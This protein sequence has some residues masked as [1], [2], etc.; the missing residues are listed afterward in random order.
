MHVAR[1]Q[2]RRSDRQACALPCTE[3]LR[4]FRRPSKAPTVH[5]R[6][7]NLIFPTAEQLVTDLGLER[8]EVFNDDHHE[9]RARPYAGSSARK[10]SR[11][12]ASGRR[13]AF[14]RPACSARP[15]P[16]EFA[17]GRADRIRR[18]RRRLPASRDPARGNGL[19]GRR[20]QHG[21]GLGIDGS[22]YLIPPAARK[23]RKRE[24][25]PR[26][27]SGETIAEACFTEPQSGSDVAGFR[28]D[29]AATATTTW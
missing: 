16:R 15:A 4:R 25:L 27:A 8:R 21:G 1:R 11:T 6:R 13:T 18:W 26:Y 28:T 20:R 19:L 9:F 7:L 24:W 2:V 3:A 22:S 29:S 10:S 23:N 14:S 17:G 12:T 5:R